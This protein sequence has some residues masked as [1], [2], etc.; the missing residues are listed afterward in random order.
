[1]DLVP[2]VLPKREIIIVFAVIM[3]HMNGFPLKLTSWYSVYPKI[4]VRIPEMWGLFAL[5]TRL[6]TVSYHPYP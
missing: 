3:K 5:G 2:D 1:M 4:I 6:N